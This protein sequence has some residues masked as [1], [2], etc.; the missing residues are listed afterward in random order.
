MITRPE[1]VVQTLYKNFGLRIL[2]RL[3]T[4]HENR[5]ARAKE[6]RGESGAFHI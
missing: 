3:G 5:L 1:F 2:I 4:G 6:G